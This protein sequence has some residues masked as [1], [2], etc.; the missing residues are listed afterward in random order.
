M[1]VNRLGVRKKHPGIIRFVIGLGFGG[2]LTIYSFGFI[3][4]GHGTAAPL[5]FTVPFIVLVTV[6]AVIPSLLSGPLLWAL[7]FFLV[8]R[9]QITL[10]RTITTIAILSVHILAGTWVAIEDPAFAR[11][12]NEKPTG[13]GLFALLLAITMAYL[14][15]FAMRN[16]PRES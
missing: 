10:M 5:V 1:N 11:A 12:L 15:Y 3:G 6:G 4:V 8:P 16:Q 2:V 13:V 14:S 9:I 7:Y